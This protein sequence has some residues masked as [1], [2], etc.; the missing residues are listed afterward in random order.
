M[1]KVDINDNKYNLLNS[2]NYN[3]FLISNLKE[4]VDNY[5]HILLNYI[6]LFNK[7]ININNEN[8][9]YFIF[10]KGIYT[11]NN[12]FL[13]ILYYTKNLE[14]AFYHSQNSYILY[15]EF[16]EQINI[17]SSNDSIKISIN[18]AISFVYKKNIYS[19]KNLIQNNITEQEKEL[20]QHFEEL[21]KIYLLMIDIF[22]LNLL[23]LLNIIN[24]F[25]LNISFK[26]KNLINIFYDFL[27]ILFLFDI[28][29]SQK[30]II[31]FLFIDEINSKK[32]INFISLKNKIQSFDIEIDD[33]QPINIINSLFN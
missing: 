23:E 1:T 31:L 9:K 28:D 7:K 26:N 12:I 20:F 10:K 15:I 25:Q 19:M 22:N 2:N 5:V 33:V 3:N 24:N 30:K 27:N 8:I 16:I 6:L 13:Y 4:I 17:T 29:V 21:I 11:I 14:I 18:D 32:N